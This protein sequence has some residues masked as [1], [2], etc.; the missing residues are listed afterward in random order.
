MSDIKNNNTK[1]NRNTYKPRE[2]INADNGTSRVTRNTDKRKRN[3]RLKRQRNIVVLAGIIIVLFLSGIIGLL[4]RKNADEVLVGEQSIG[5]IKKNTIT[6]VELTNFV[7]AQLESERSTKVQLNEKIVLK[8]VRVDKKELVTQENITTKVREA[9]TYKVEAASITADNAEIAILNNVEEA[10]T[11]LDSIM[12]EYIPEGASIV[13]ELSGFVQKVEVSKK[14]VE[15]TQIMSTDEVKKKFTEGTMSTKPYT[16]ASKDTLYKIATNAGMTVEKLL[17][18]NPGM[19]IKSVLVVG[20]Q[21]NITVNTP[22]L[23]VKTVENSV[24]TEK[25][26]K[27]KEIRKD[28]TK[29]KSYQKVIQQG[30]DGQQEVTVQIIR[31]NGFEEEQKIISTKVTQEPVTEIIVVGTK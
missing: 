21:I 8:P 18:V 27:E 1:R 4:T 12:N 10:N 20:K 28:E 24:Y 17:E 15:S 5:Y 13:K 31:V 25:K 2:S 19:N 9:V 7:V 30:K 6:D 11:L 16:I 14:F 23:S 26:A 29:S 3:K 22:F